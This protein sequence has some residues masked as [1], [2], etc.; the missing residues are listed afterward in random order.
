MKKNNY[1]IVFVFIL[2]AVDLWAQGI[3]CIDAENLLTKK[4]NLTLEKALQYEAD[5]FNRLF[6]DKT[7]NLSDIQLTVATNYAEFISIQSKYGVLHAYASGFFSPKDSVLVVLKDKKSKVNRFLPI[8]YHELSHAFLHL[9]KNDKYL[10]AW[11]DEGLADYLEQ[12]TY[13]KSKITQR[14][15]KQSVIRV[16]TLIDLRDLNL[17]EFVNWSYQKFSTESF[18]QEGYGYAVAYCM[19]LFLMQQGED[20]AFAIFR[21]LLDARSTIEVFDKHYLG[22][23]SQFETDFIRYFG[24]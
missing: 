19:T 12:M 20:K 23:F 4:E 2:L 15:N 5:F 9:H 10:P 24:R 18:A 17:A 14:I 3:K 16:K 7:V 6:P 8:C 21:N 13:D 22:G 1:S 11:F